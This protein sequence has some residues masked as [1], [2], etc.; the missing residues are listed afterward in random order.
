MK[1]EVVIEKKSAALVNV[2]HASVIQLTLLCDK[3][4]TVIFLLHGN[5]DPVAN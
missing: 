2:L 5:K 1:K 4:V 3:V